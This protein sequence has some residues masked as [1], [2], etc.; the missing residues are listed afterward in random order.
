MY[1]LQCFM[2]S[3]SG[4]NSVRQRA[5]QTCCH[6][7]VDLCPSVWRFSQHRCGIGIECALRARLKFVADD[8]SRFHVHQ[9][10]PRLLRVV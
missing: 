3:N 9:P 8:S 7:M 10:G 2:F 1:T 5:W 4:G 6:V